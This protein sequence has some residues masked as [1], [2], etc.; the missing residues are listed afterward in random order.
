MAFRHMIS[1]PNPVGFGACGQN[2][3]VALDLTNPPTP[4]GAEHTNSCGLGD[5]ADFT[6]NRPAQVPDPF[7]GKHGR[8]WF[9]KDKS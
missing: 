6:E 5:R 4:H 9:G 2:L 8:V 1:T 7:T 3:P